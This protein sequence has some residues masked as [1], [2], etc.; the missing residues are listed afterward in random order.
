MISKPPSILY[1][2][3][4]I[5]VMPLVK[6]HSEKSFHSRISV[7]EATL[8]IDGADNQIPL[9]YRKDPMK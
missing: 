5:D 3:L 8:A 6:K 9:I 1:I 7:F 4:A 2:T